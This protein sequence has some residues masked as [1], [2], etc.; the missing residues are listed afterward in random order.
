VTEWISTLT[1]I[2]APLAG[3][4]FG[5]ALQ[6]DFAKISIKAKIW[7]WFLSAS[8]AVFLGPYIMHRFFGEDDHPSAVSFWMFTISALAL[9]VGPILIGRVMSYAKRV[10]INLLPKDDK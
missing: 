10:N 7:R 2:S 9:S 3:A 8:A 4:A 6:P 5:I 1:A